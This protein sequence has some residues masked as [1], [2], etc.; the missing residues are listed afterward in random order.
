ME[1]N[2]AITWDLD[3]RSRHITRNLCYAA[4]T[5]IGHYVG[6]VSVIVR[7]LTTVS[8]IQ[9]ESPAVFIQEEIM[10]EQNLAEIIL[11]I[12]APMM[13]LFGF[14]LRRAFTRLEQ[15]ISKGEIRV[16]I[17]DRLG[18]LEANQRNV[19]NEM[20]RIEKKLDRI[21]DLLIETKIRQSKNSNGRR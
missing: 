3:L 6:R 15:T 10:M 13:G 5:R 19:E 9:C 14:M 1:D 12:M 4:E 2:P 17:S 20:R 7:K 16:L 11:I 18:P 21:I 8:G